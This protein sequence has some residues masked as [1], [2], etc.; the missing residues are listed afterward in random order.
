ML[1][2][3]YIFNTIFHSVCNKQLSEEKNEQTKN[4]AMVIFHA[5]QAYIQ[6]HAEHTM[7][8]SVKYK[9]Y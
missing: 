1:L 5:K 8:K 6:S 7:Q 4:L 3:Q 2:S 9:K